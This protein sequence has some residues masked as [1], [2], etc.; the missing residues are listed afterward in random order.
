MVSA[1]CYLLSSD[2]TGPTDDGSISPQLSLTTVLRL[3]D[4]PRT[5]GDF[6]LILSVSS[7][8]PL[9]NSLLYSPAPYNWGRSGHLAG[10][11]GGRYP[12][13]TWA[14]PNNACG[15]RVEATC[16]RPRLPLGNVAHEGVHHARSGQMGSFWWQAIFSRSAVINHFFALRAQLTSS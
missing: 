15:R 11:V 8:A 7:Y 2:S 13:P 12:R 14:T 9:N 10:L 3:I 4:R 1:L 5:P 6:G 16:G